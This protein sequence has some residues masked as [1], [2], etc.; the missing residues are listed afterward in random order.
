MHGERKKEQTSMASYTNLGNF[1]WKLYKNCP[2]LPSNFDILDLLL[3]FSFYQSPYF[4][5]VFNGQSSACRNLLNK[6]KHMS[7]ILS[8][9]YF[10]L[11]NLTQ[12]KSGTDL[13]NQVYLYMREIIVTFIYWFGTLHAPGIF[14]LV[15]CL[16]IGH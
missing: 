5:G 9:C 16:D 15:Y 11:G 6:P 7:A 2:F 10:P 1:A 14:A 8:K 4:S 12:Q 13:G 3:Q